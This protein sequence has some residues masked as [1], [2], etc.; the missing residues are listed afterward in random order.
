MPDQITVPPLTATPVAGTDPALGAALAAARLPVADLADP[1]PQFFAF[2]LP[3]TAERLYGGVM[4]LEQ[5][6]LL[7]SILVPEGQRRKG[8][9]SAVLAAL[10]ETAQAAGAQDLWALSPA[11]AAPFFTRRGFREVARYEAP[12]VV[13]H[14][15][16]A[17]LT[18]PISTVIL[19]RAL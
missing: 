18:C 8:L 4:M 5:H 19:T 1:G 13:L 12:Q 2:A 14:A 11:G 9:G 16:L 17:G 6:A 10:M 15:R 7:R 3:D